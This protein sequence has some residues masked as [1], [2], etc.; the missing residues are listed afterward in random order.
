MKGGNNLNDIQA[1]LCEA[2]TKYTE[3]KSQSKARYWMDYLSSRIHNYGN[4]LDV[5][6]QHHP[7]YV[8]LAW[9]AFKFLLVV[10]AISFHEF[11]TKSFHSSIIDSTES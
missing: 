7:E 8:S 2:K 6:V 11:P 5:L 3:K 4:I 9:G 1:T 10:S